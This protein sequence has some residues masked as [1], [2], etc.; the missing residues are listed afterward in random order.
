[1]IKIEVI[2]EAGK[3]VY[4]TENR[5]YVFVS[6]ADGRPISK[7]RVSVSGIEKEFVT[8]DLGVVSITGATSRM[9]ITARDAQGHSGSRSVE[10]PLAETGEDFLVRTDRA[11]YNGGDTMHISAWGFGVE[12]VFIDLIKDGQTLLTTTIERPPGK[13]GSAEAGELK[14][15]LPPELSGT[16]L[17][18]AYRYGKEGLPVRKTR[19]LYIR[20][21]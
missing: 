8:S 21:A 13:P 1:P 7:A 18:C 14:L 4:C 5:V 15:D 11:V 2:P 10:L 3:L 16:V 12:P 20:P 6:Y 9:T 19:V 17:L